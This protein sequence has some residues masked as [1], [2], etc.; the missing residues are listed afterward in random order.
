ML[1]TIDLFAGAGGL[2]LGFQL[3]GGF[4]IVAAAEINKYARDTYKANIAKNDPDFVFIENVLGYDFS[5]LNERMGGIDIVIGGPPCQGFSNA[6]RQKNHV[7]SMN[8]GLVKEFFRAIKEIKPRAFV[9]E[10]VSMLR[11]DTHRF[12][13][14]AVDKDQIDALIEAGFSIPTRDDTLLVADRAFDGIDYENLD[15]SVFQSVKMPAD[16]TQLIV[17]LDKNLYNPRR[18]PTY[19]KK[20]SSQICTKTKAFIDSDREADTPAL[21]ALI[22]KLEEVIAA[23]QNGTVEAASEDI[24]YIVALQKAVE[25]LGEI[26]ENRLIGR[27]EAEG[28]NL[29]FRV[30][31]Y[32]VIDYIK[33]ILGGE[34]I[35]SGGTVNAKWFGVPQDRK[36]YIVMGIRSDVCSGNAFS[37]PQ[38]P[39][40]Y[41]AVTVGEA[42]SDLSKYAASYEPTSNETAYDEG[43]QGLSQYATTM[44]EGSSGVNNHITT[45]TTQTALDRFKAIKQGDNFHSLDVEMKSTYSKPERTQKT[46]YLRLNPNEPSG[47][48]VNVRKSMWI[49]PT[50]DR[51][52]TIREAARLQSFPDRFVFHGAKDSQYQQVGNAVPPFLARAIATHLYNVI[53]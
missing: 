3:A 50:L 4:R 29:L 41:S 40:E 43:D 34:Y 11:S 51:A 42:I 48:V 12:Y 15:V 10:N 36:R 44:R 5:A 2:S 45:K 16:L 35:Q 25:T 31:S 20:H 6:N 32:S 26:K 46:I 14:S 18:L 33:A 28:N 52:I 39:D 17:V 24:K 49:H 27:Y 22:T 1:K 9:M 19:L 53:K 30:R 37:I 23:M 13:E 21:G 38:E 47:T 7:I 8:N